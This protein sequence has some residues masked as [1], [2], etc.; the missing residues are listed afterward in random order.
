M[1]L[2]TTM[3]NTIFTLRKH[4]PEILTV[5][6]VL[7]MGAGTVLACMAT[8]KLEKELDGPIEHLTL[9][10]N[11]P[12]KHDLKKAYLRLLGTYAKLY[13]PAI[14]VEILSAAG[15]MAGNRILRKRNMALAAAYATLDA[16]YRAYRERVAK[17][18]GDDVEKEILTGAHKE[19]IEVTEADENGKEKKIK[20]EVLVAGD[21]GPSDFCRYFMVGETK[22]AVAN[23]EYNRFFLQGQ[24][25]VANRMLELKG[26]LFLN[27]VLEM[28]GYKPTIAGQTVGWVYDKNGNDDG[29]NYIDFGMQEIWRKTDEGMQ[30]GYFLNFN[31]DGAILEHCVK[32]GLIER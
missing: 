29:D 9:A 17:R 22:A 5:T 21:S 30:N 11:D 32:N 26:H 31:V 10:K 20:K 14:A 23:N 19:K 2:K 16:G 24:Q 3:N 27:E 28:L 13:G 18:F 15:I 25:E 6:G 1:N 7:G 8:K 12:E 4:S